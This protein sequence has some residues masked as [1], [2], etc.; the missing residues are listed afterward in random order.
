MEERSDVGRG[1]GVTSGLRKRRD[2]HR[3]VGYGNHRRPRVRPRREDRGTD[4]RP[5]FSDQSEV[6]E[7]TDRSLAGGS[8]GTG[9]TGEN[10]HDV[11]WGLSC[12]RGIVRRGRDDGRNTPSC[13]TDGKEGRPDHDP[14]GSSPTWSHTGR[15]STGAD[16][17]VSGARGR[18]RTFHPRPRGFL[19]PESSCFQTTASILSRVRVF[20]QVRF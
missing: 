18:Q 2:R 1:L 12:G 17:T 16:T 7:L 10:F 8:E 13:P 20:L 4:R 9:T 15:S 11:F 6:G 5:A 3:L 14:T 19:G